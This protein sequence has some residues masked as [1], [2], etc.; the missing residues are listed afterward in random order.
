MKKVF[1][2]ILSIYAES[3]AEMRKDLPQIVLCLSFML[4]II[5]ISLSFVLWGKAVGAGS[6]L[7]Y[8]AVQAWFRSLKG[9]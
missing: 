9:I 6:A 8:L 3:F 7:F 1:K 5:V 4:G 2:N